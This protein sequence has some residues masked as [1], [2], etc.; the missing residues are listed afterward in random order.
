MYVCLLVECAVCSVTALRHIAW[1][2]PDSAK[3][4]R[5]RKKQQR[6]GAE[7][8]WPQV[9]RR[10]GGT[11]SRWAVCRVLVCVRALIVLAVSHPALAGFVH[12]S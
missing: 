11:A 12:S 9:G 6:C 5:K 3:E 10:D 8:E 1:P 4:R 7:K 2:L